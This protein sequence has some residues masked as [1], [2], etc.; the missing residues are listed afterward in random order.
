MQPQARHSAPFTAQICRANHGV[1]SSARYR[2]HRAHGGWARRRG[3]PRE[4]RFMVRLFL[5]AMAFAVIA[6]AAGAQDE[7]A[8]IV[9]ECDRRAASNLDPQRPATVQG[10][11]VDAIDPKAAIPACEAALKV[12]PDDRRIMFQLGRAYAK[13]QNYEKARI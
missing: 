10:V 11:P 3:K 9:G 12:V 13:A 8:R 4:I 6:T 2:Y 1:T 7:T 5:S